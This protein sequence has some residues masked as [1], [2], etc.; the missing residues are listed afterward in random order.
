M[1]AFPLLLPL[2]LLAACERPTPAA[3]VKVAD[4][5]CRAAPAGA[6]SAACY[7]TVTAG[8]ADKLIAVETA[9]ADHAEIHDMDMSGG[10]MRMRELKDGLPLPAGKAVALAP[11]GLH[12]MLIRPKAAIAEGSTVSLVL[13][14][15][16]APAK[17]IA[18]PVR[19]AVAGMHH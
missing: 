8:S 12:L 11:G 18:A 2:L 1:K 10:V 7:L 19:S 13:K 5:W 4:A 9:V 3:D 16:H 14:F 6:L 17:T 15:E